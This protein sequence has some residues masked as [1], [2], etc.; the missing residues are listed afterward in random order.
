MPL[1]E[2]APGELVD[3]MTILELKLRHAVQGRNAD[4]A[5]AQLKA[6]TDALGTLATPAP[7]DLVRQLREINQRL[8]TAEDAIRQALA[9]VKDTDMADLAT[10]LAD[11]AETIA[12]LNDRRCK[13]KAAIDE[14]LD[15]ASAEFKV[16]APANKRDERVT[17][18]A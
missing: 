6:V 1:L 17:H 14:A 13:V 9:A 7:E 5:R 10:G 2:I 8:W 18:L 16:Y 12:R 3:R 4:A 11:W 15:V